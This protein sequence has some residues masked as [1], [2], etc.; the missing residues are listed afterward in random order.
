MRIFNSIFQKSS[1]ELFRIVRDWI[2]SLSDQQRFPLCRIKIEEEDLYVFDD[3]AL[4]AFGVRLPS[5][6]FV[7]LA[8]AVRNMHQK[9]IYRKRMIL[10]HI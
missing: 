9:N 7:F 3:Q 2:S 1:L 5:F 8:A 10:E 6:V 4:A